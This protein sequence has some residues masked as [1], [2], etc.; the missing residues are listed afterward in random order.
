MVKDVLFGLGGVVVL[1]VCAVGFIAA[2]VG[3]NSAV[4]FL[5]RG[6]ARKCPTLNMAKLCWWGY[7]VVAFIAMS[8]SFITV[9]GTTSS[10]GAFIAV[11]IMKGVMGILVAG[12]AAFL[13][14]ALVGGPLQ[15]SFAAERMA[16]LG[17]SATLTYA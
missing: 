12:I 3:M 5:G 9:N 15:R 1:L 4:R 8:I 14:S 11:L 17:Q 16:R 10:V 2:L 13:A 6:L 7:F